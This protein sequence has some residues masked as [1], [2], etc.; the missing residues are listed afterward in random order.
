MGEITTTGANTSE[1]EGVNTATG[2]GGDTETPTTPAGSGAPLKF[3]PEQQTEIDRIVAERLAREADKVAK[4]NKAAAD[5]AEEERLKAQGEYQTLA[6]KAEAER[7]AALAQAKNLS[8]KYEAAVVAARLNISKPDIALRLVDLDKV[9]FDG[10]G[11]PSNLDKLLQE[12]I[13]EVPG[14]VA[15]TAPAPVPTAPPV[16]GGLPTN[17][18][19]PPGDKPPTFD[20]KNPPSLFQPGIFKSGGQG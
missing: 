13:K 20:P 19:T 5:K 3:T 7:D 15:Q 14:L 10:E 16:K 1:G 6:Q 8:L 9:E 17:P 11:K 2:T 4:A 18:Q 12:V